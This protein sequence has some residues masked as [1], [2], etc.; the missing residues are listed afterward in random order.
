MKRQ[1]SSLELKRR[2][3]I[4]LESLASN[5]KRQEVTCNVCSEASEYDGGSV[6]Q[7]S[8]RTSTWNIIRGQASKRL[9]RSHA[10]REASGSK[11]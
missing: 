4:T 10:T 9:W 2:W 5:D 11:I 6:H 7:A 8:F 3:S 1:T